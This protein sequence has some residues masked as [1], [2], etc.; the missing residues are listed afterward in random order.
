MKTKTIL[1]KGQAGIYREFSYL[2][3]L[4]AFA[5][6]IS[7]SSPEGNIT[8]LK[9]N[10]RIRIEMPVNQYIEVLDDERTAKMIAQEPTIFLDK[11]AEVENIKLAI[12]SKNLNKELAEK[13]KELEKELALLAIESKNLNEE[14]VEKNKELEKALALLKQELANK[15]S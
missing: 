7:Q 1:Y 5:K 15:K 14:L 13:N 6:G 2:E 12:E 8:E 9:K 4:E 11:T 3:S 10:R